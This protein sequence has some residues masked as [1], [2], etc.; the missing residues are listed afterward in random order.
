MIPDLSFG[1]VCIPYDA[2]EGCERCGR[3]L[4]GRRRRWCTDECREW[5]YANHRWTQARE[6]AMRRTKGKCRRCGKRAEEVD[7]VMEREGLPLSTW[8]CLTRRVWERAPTMDEEP[9]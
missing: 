3:P 7:H 1:E 6:E 9:E 2:S 8:S 4:A 5:S